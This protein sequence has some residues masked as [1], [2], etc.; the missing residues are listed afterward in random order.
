M[1][2]MKV[3]LATIM[4]LAICGV[5]TSWAEAACKKPKVVIVLDKSSSMVTGMVGSQTKWAVAKN[6]IS[7]VV[8]TYQTTIDFGLMLFPNPSQ[9]GPGKVVVPIG[10]NNATAILNKLA[11]PPPQ[12]GNWT[13]MAQSLDVAAGH[14]ALQDS[15]YSNNVLLVTDGWQWCSPYDASTRFLPVNS[16]SNLTALGITTYVVGFGESVDTLTLNKMAAAAKT[17]V[18]KNCNVAG[19]DYKATNNCYYQANSP[20]DLLTALQTIALKVTAEVCDNQDNDCDGLVDENLTNTCSTV[21]GTGTET[22]VNGVWTG[23]TAPQPPCGCVEGQTQPCGTAVGQCTQGTQT[24]TN[25]T[26]G[27][28]TGGVLPSAE[29]CDSMDNDC[30]G[31]TDENLS[32]T[33]QSAC[34]AG[35]EVCTN[36]GWSGCT[37][38]QPSQEI[39]DG[40]DN[41]CDGAI[42]GDDAICDNGGVCVDGVCV[43]P[44]G[45]GS[46]CDCALG[47]EGTVPELPLLLLLALAVVVVVARRR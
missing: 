41:D 16:T 19:T 39:C 12:S 35:T 20:Q 24:C 4:V 5:W 9:C 1:R 29:V 47:G 17:K 44:G 2:M 18:S 36:G 25:G 33:C 26:W 14:T 28:C 37:A 10:P 8:S 15:A 32:R 23:C 6:A 7:Q 42:D 27:S 11:D 22:C 43:I 31:Q 34:G 40:L 3:T 21:C 46:G 13:P 38:P 45:D 30:N